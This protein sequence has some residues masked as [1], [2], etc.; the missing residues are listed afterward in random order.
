MLGGMTAPTFLV[1]GAM[2]SATT[3]LARYLSV[4]PEIDIPARSR[5]GYFS[6]S[7]LY[8]RG[9][10]WYAA[11]FKRGRQVRGEVAPSYSKRH[12]APEVAARIHEALPDCRLVYSVRDPINRA[13]SHYRHR[14]ARGA[15]SR[16]ISAALSPSAGNPYLLTGRY[17]WQLEPFRQLF[18]A[19]HILVVVAEELREDR[20]TVLSRL[21][22]FL[23]A[24]PVA[25]RAVGDREYHRGVDKREGGWLPRLL[26]VAG[27]D[28]V[29]TRVPGP[30]LGWGGR[31]IP[32]PTIDEGL[33]RE[34]F[35]YFADDIEVVG[36]LLG[37]MPDWPTAGRPE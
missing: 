12:V 14:R 24:G 34:L 27:W 23:G 20:V 3:S 10:S 6:R 36:N 2:K 26:S 21:C 11:H 22:T 16:T 25:T 13:L 19:D 29:L 15:E 9:F 1:I 18:P 17:A 31:S 35:D 33:R 4:H 28:G 30:M 32:E 8:R 7:E 37:R 5:V